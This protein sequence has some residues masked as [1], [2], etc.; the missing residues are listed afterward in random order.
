MNLPGMYT[1][2]EIIGDLHDRNNTG[3]LA[4][5]MPVAYVIVESHA[6]NAEP[7]QIRCFDRIKE[8]AGPGMRLTR[9]LPK[10]MDREIESL[11]DPVGCIGRS[12]GRIR[13][14]AARI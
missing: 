4:R 7:E 2:A 1:L 12:C 8:E 9:Y 10:G 5:I 13:R 14:G 11:A 6:G 3:I